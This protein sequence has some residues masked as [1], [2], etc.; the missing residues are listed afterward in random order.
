MSTRFRVPAV[1]LVACVLVALIGLS[2]C[3]SDGGSDRLTVYS[4]RDEE[5]IEPLIAEFTDETGIEVDVRYGDSSDLALLI[6]EEG[7]QAPAD[8]FLS[9]SP[10][11]IGYLDTKDRLG[12]IPADV[13]DVVDER[14]RASDGHWV[15]ISGRVRVL[16][17]NT[18]LVDEAELPSSVFDLTGEEYGDKVA[19]APT[20]GSFQDFITA[21]R[22]SEGDEEARAWLDGMAANG[23]RSYANNTAIV[24]AVGRGEMPM[25]LVNHYYLERAKAEDPGV[26][27]TNYFFEDGDIGSLV[28]V[29]A[30][31]VLDTADNP[32]GAEQ[33]VEFL[34]SRASQEFFAEET[35]EYPL[36]RSVAAAQDLP[37]LDEIASPPV[38]LS[39]LGGGLEATRRMIAASGLEQS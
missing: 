22:A 35:F 12:G 3:S 24:E 20:N 13:L 18:D 15:G 17:Y 28:L 33:F 9:Q 39:S 2:A 7:D 29:T 11:A 16:V 5:L 21:M 4:G 38:D 27:A 32:D 25:G 30:A 19:L 36:A 8:L 6:D 34:L 23:A 14:F 10:G 37:P 1:A 26:P 31:G